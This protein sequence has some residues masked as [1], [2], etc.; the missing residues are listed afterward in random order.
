MTEK[1]TRGRRSKVQLLPDEIKQALHEMLRD[2]QLE[3]QEILLIVNQQIKAA[4]LEEDAVLSRSGLNRYATR[5]EIV[6]AR[7]R[8]SREAAEAWTAQLGDKPITETSQLLQEIV[9]TLAFDATLDIATSKETIDP[10]VLSQLALVSQRVEQAA[11][12][13]HKREKEIRKEFAAQA[14]DAAETVAKS[15]GL[16]REGVEKIKAEILGIA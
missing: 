9:R 6:G 11:S 13:S 12:A 15:Q 2:G 1:K 8:Q 4:G 16:T 14:A 5:M 3:Q 10:K 7:I